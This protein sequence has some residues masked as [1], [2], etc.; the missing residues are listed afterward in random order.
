MPRNTYWADGYIEKRR[1]A[2]QAISLI[3]DGAR[4]FIGTA[5]GEPQHLVQ[6]LRK[7]TAHLRHI[8]V[9]GLLVS[10]NVPGILADPNAASAGQNWRIFYGGSGFVPEIR[11]RQQF[12]T[13]NSLAAVP[14]LFQERLLPLHCALIQATPPDDFGWMSLGVSVDVTAA[15]AHAADMVIVQVNSEMPRSHGSGFIHVNDVDI[16]VEKNEPLLTLASP[17]A[18]E[19]PADDLAGTIAGYVARLV[20]DEATLQINP[21]RFSTAILKALSGKRDLGIHSQ[22]IFDELMHLVSSGVVTN[23]CKGGNKGISIAAT[24]V[25]STHL[26]PFLDDNPAVELRPS[27]YVN[28]AAVIASQRRMTA[29]NEVGLIDLTGQITVDSSPRSRMSGITGMTDFL[30]GAAQAEQGRPIVILSARNALTQA[31]NIVFSLNN[32]AVVVGRGDV[33]YVVTEY[34]AVN[35][36][37]KSMQ[38]RALALISIAHPDDRE[39]LFVQARE[40]GLMGADRTLRETLRSVYPLKREETFLIKNQQ[41]TLRPVKP[42]DERRLQEHFYNMDKDDVLLRF[43]YDKRRFV[44]TEM[45]GMLQ[46]DYMDNLALAAITGEFGFG[47]IVALGAY[48]MEESGLAEVAFS[49]LKEYQRFGLGRLLLHK[50][51]EAARENGIKGLVAYTFPHNRGMIKLFSTLPYKIQR[52]TEY[53]SVRLSIRFDELR[54]PEP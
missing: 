6:A 15:A 33:Y 49:V 3:G 10:Q 20:D 17:S 2:D 18:S 44:R 50:L 32:T 41:I 47:R 52:R 54:E 19:N 23:R 36:F 16:I 5:C 31:S 29:I 45:E 30:Y 4:V 24:A 43:F 39:A 7:Q 26:Y 25:G 8:E 51:A 14:R 28:N 9:V 42:V 48:A 13:P 38:E 1:S 37:G 34:G 46:I 22:F 53:D 11:S 21:G 40:Q 12:I 27:S 35:L